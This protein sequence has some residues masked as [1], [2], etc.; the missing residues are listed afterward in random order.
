M[1]INDHL[2]I[3]WVLC[4]FISSIDSFF[5]SSFFFKKKGCFFDVE[6]EGL[7]NLQLSLSL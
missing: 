7:C 2:I 6:Y 4:V 1:E 5:L 3:G